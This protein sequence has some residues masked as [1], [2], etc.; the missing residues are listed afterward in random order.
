MPW[1][2]K[3]FVVL[4]SLA[5]IFGKA[6]AGQNMYVVLSEGDCAKRGY[7]WITDVAKCQAAARSVGWGETVVNEVQW[8]AP[9]GC[10]FSKNHGAAKVN[11]NHYNNNPKP[12]SAKYPCVCRAAGMCLN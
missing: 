11:R 8:I 5:M 4:A 2:P 12:C 6:T 3:T 10:I 7:D 9:Y 1:S